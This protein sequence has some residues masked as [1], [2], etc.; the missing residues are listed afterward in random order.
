MGKT[1][2]TYEPP[3][4]PDGPFPRDTTPKQPPS[5]LDLNQ[6]L[7][8]K[9]SN[10][11]IFGHPEK[12]QSFAAQMNGDYRAVT[13]PPYVRIKPTN[14]CDDGCTYC[15]SES[16]TSGMR[17]AMEHRAAWPKEKMH[18]ILDDFKAIGVKGVTYSGGGEPLIYA[19][20]K[21]AL[22]KTLDYGI[23]LSIITNGSQLR[24][25]KAELLSQAHWVRLSIDYSDPETFFKIRRRPAE[26]FVQR[27]RNIQGFAKIKPKGCDFGANYV[28]SHASYDKIFESARLFKEWGIE[29]VRFSPVYTTFVPMAQL[30]ANIKDQALEQIARAKAELE[31][32][33]F[34]IGDSYKKS[35]DGAA[36]EHRVYKHCLIMQTVPTI[37]AGQAVF[38]CHNK[39]D[40]DTG[41]LGDIITRKFSDLWFSDEAAKIMRDFNCQDNCKHEC[42]N[43]AKNI[44]YH[45]LLAAVDPKDVNFPTLV[46]ALLVEKDPETM[47]ILSAINPGANP[48]AVRQEIKAALDPHVVN[49]P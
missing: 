21:D 1:N 43:D 46:N 10:L 5:E 26:D 17:H 3:Q 49:F 9:Y 30:H 48:E 34:K 22:K 6:G 7:G 28:V 42:A 16:A 29:N 15:T 14:V 8:G 18:E 24:S 23:Q 37:G 27:V 35:F 39:N 11:K 20:I 13:A 12:L 44:F 36:L 31:D 33:H 38:F 40:S 47:R 2:V 19:H 32:D 45:R 25:E 41:K 4:V